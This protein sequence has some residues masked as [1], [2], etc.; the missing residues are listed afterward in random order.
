M[1]GL[2]FKQR[3]SQ[4]KLAAAAGDSSKWYQISEKKKASDDSVNIV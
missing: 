1:M 3:G 2:G 4:V